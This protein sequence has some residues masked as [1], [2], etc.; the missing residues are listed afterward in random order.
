ME[1][2]TV[3]VSFMPIFMVHYGGLVSDEAFKDYLAQ[4]ERTLYAADA[5]PRVIIH[6]A[7]AA[8]HNPPTQRKLQAEWLKKH[9]ARL[10]EITLGSV[11][12]I[13]SAL[14]RGI[15]TAILWLQPLA[16]PHEVCGTVE[17]AL[18]WSAKRLKER[19]LALVP[20]ARTAILLKYGVRKTAR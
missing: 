9:D 11:F 8:G 10:R 16:M 6:D 2:I 18:D 3:D 15:L 4:V 1:C 14:V 20:T 12:V 5:R 19:N 7:R 13:D 17:E